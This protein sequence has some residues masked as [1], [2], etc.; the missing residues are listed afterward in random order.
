MT[1]TG[2]SAETNLQGGIPKPENSLILKEMKHF[3]RNN[4]PELSYMI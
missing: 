1:K 4:T 3:S 2:G